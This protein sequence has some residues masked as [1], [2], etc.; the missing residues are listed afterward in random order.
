MRFPRYCAVWLGL[1]FVFATIVG[2]GALNYYRLMNK[3][4][5]TEAI[6]EAKK[7]HEQI[8]Y[9]F[10]AEDRVYMGVGMAGFG[11]PP[12]GS[13]STGDRVPVHYLPGAPQIN[14]A[15]D[16]RQLFSNELFV[17]LLVAVLFPSMIVAWLAFRHRRKNRMGSRV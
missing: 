17:V 3:G 15:G 6:V 14:C 11:T 7:P 13:I 2:R 12:V 1:A 10:K 9:S 4:V 8:E 5:L 16:P